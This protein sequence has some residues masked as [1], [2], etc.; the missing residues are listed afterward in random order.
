M[1]AGQRGFTYMMVL[2]VIAIASAGM[3]IAGTVWSTAQ[4]REREVQLLWVGNQMRAAIASY[5][6][7]SPGGPQFPPTLEHLLKDPRFPHTVRHLRQLYPDPIT[8]SG[9]WGLIVAH[10][11]GIM[12]VY[13]KSEGKPWKRKGFEGPNASFADR[14]EA[15]GDKF[16]YRDW[17]FVYVPG[18][19]GVA[20]PQF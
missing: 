3:A 8:G 15:L 7:R 9:D 12:G 14:A 1:R 16:S 20:R 11:G 13:S 2:F 17:Q 10:G 4:Q 5:Y 19:P 6:H 18:M